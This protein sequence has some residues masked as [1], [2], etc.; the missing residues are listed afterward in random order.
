MRCPDMKPCPVCGEQIQDVAVKCRYC[1]EI[2]DPSLTQQRHSK[3]RAPWY[4]KLLFGLLWWIVLYMATSV[5]AAGIAGGIAGSRDP[6]NAQAA[7]RRAGTEV[8]EKYG[9]A[10][11]LGS[12]IVAFSCAGFGVLPGTRGD[13]GS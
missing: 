7:G 11:L 12:A 8:G 4:R 10:M 6:Q 5:L 2:F 9:A 13:G 3:G 1:G